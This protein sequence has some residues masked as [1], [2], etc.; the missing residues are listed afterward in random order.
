MWHT[1]LL[2][3][4]IHIDASSFSPANN[5]GV[6]TVS[7]MADDDGKCGSLGNPLWVDAGNMSGLAA[8]DTFALFSNYGNDIDISAP[9]VNIT[10]TSSNGTYALAGGTSIAA[11]T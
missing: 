3:G 9:G 1:S 8:D 4:N 2:A 7:A 10:T 11:L 6:I 5:P